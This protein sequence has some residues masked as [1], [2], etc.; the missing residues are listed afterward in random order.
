MY[1]LHHQN[2]NWLRLNIGP[3]KQTI[4]FICQA[5]HLKYDYFSFPNFI[6]VCFIFQLKYSFWQEIILHFEIISDIYLKNAKIIFDFF[7][8][9]C[10]FGDNIYQH[11]VSPD[12]S[13]QG[14]GNDLFAEPLIYYFNLLPISLYIFI[15]TPS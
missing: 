2:Y 6:C 14:A 13:I 8:F 5:Q 11:T 7:E 9:D 15:Y 10:H 12:W 4:F 1:W 3:F